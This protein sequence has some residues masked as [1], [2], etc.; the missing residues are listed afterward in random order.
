MKKRNNK[1]K[2]VIAFVGLLVL[3]ILSDFTQERLIKDGSINRAEIGGKKEEVVLEVEV[4]GN[5]KDYTLEIMP[6]QPTK[7]EAGK[8]FDAAIAEIDMDFQDFED[9]I[10]KKDS[11]LD[12]VV[13]A[14][15]NILPRGYL[16]GDGSI[17]YEQLN[18]EGQLMQ[19]SVMLSCGNYERVYNFSFWI[20]PKILS[21]EEK[22]MQQLEEYLREQMEQEGSK[23]IE[24]PTQLNGTQLKWSRKQEYKTPIIF[25]L[26]IIA[27]GLLWLSI[28]EKRKKE[29]QQ[30]MLQMEREYPN[31]VNQ[32]SFLLG[33]GMTIRQAW[34]RISVQYVFKRKEGMM[35]ENMVYEAIT[36]MN[37]RLSEGESERSVYQ[38]FMQEIPATSYRR[39]MRM[40]L[41]SMEKGM[42]GLCERLEEESRLAYEKRVVQAKKLGEEASTKMLLPLMMMLTVVM[43]IVILPALIEFQM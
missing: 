11:Y 40:L 26:E 14:K 34:N 4:D 15:W 20:L 33:A 9:K 12:G 17:R 37:R 30:K 18:E 22:N 43:G 19:T 8:Y 35:K 27:L 29:E 32:L 36:R 25:L 31:I 1:R 16:A 38:Q 5:V 3:S 6:A 23:Q 28:K 7:E 13:K 42:L 10:P 2:V 41:G 21:Q 39:L 24:L